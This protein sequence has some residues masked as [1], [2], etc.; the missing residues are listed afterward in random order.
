MRTFWIMKGIKIAVLFILFAFV[1]TYAV[2][3]LW[4]WLMPV[5]FGASMITF[6]QALGLFILA[7]I[8]FGFG[9]KGGWHHRGHW[10]H[11]GHSYWKT[12][13]EERLK[14]MGPEE[15]E[16]FR[17]EWR[18]RCGKWGHYNWEEKKSEEE[19]KPNT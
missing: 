14:N 17:S 11:Q 12:K 3:L 16:K 7:K 6:W 5:V 2:M 8:L 18:Q 13:M 15:R 19:V 1:A 9:G 4:N 10:G